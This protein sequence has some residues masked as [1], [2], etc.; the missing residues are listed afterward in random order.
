MSVRTQNERMKFWDK[1]NVLTFRFFI[2]FAQ[3]GIS[4]KSS[5]NLIAQI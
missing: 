2:T 3:E 5:S 4:K 1:K